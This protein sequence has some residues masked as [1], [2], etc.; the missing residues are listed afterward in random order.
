MQNINF[1]ADAF[2]NK[3]VKILSNPG[4]KIVIKNR[5]EFFI[6]SF[7]Q[8]YLLKSLLG[9]HFG[10]ISVQMYNSI[11]THCDAIETHI[12]ASLL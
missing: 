3:K 12:C 4:F 11:D 7:I 9:Q 6:Q 1:E 5:K 10:A 8:N 2:E